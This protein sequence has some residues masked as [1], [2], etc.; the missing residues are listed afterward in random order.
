MSNVV[1]G[2]PTLAQPDFEWIQAIRSAEDRLFGAAKPHFTIVFPTEKLSIADLTDHT[3]LK[4]CGRPKVT[5]ALTKALVVED[6]SKGMF[7]AF[8]VPSIG[9]RE[10]TNLH[11]EMYTDML[12]SELHPDIPFIPHIGIA[13]IGGESLYDELWK[14]W[15]VKL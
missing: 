11:D 1:L 12:A 4:I 9:Q 6:D 10:I 8:L 7:H 3:E 13:T 15:I 14:T 5:F 2:Y